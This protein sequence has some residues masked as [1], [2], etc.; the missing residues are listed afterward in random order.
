MLSEKMVDALNE[1]INKEMYSGYMYLSMSA[2][3]DFKGLKGSANWFHV[4]YQEEM[5]HAMRI[6]D[7]VQEQGAHVKLKTI[8]QPPTEFGTPLQIFE[9][10]LEHERFVT[11]LINNLVDLAIEERDHASRIFLQWFVSEQV[12]EESNAN[13]ILDK[14]KLAGEDGN[15]LFMVDKELAAR[16]YTPPVASE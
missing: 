3:A 10:T 1:Q 14:I 8:D 13:E 16:V 6:Y 9:K 12:E 7:Y 15:G 5:E 4:Q 11:T 2:Y